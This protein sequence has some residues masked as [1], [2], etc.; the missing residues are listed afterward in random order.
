AIYSGLEGSRNED[1]TLQGGV[2]QKR[3]DRSV[4]R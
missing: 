2:L 4:Y 1:A 3:F